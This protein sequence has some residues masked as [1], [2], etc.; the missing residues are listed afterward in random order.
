MLMLLNIFKNKMDRYFKRSGVNF[1]KPCA[2]LKLDFLTR[3]YTKCLAL[4]RQFSFSKAQGFRETGAW[5]CLD[6]IIIIWDLFG[7]KFSQIQLLLFYLSACCGLTTTLGT[8]A[9]RCASSPLLQRLG[10]Y[11]PIGPDGWARTGRLRWHT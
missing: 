10:D 1:T 4:V 3:A 7:W 11:N 9:G 6:A 8:M 2:L 5:V